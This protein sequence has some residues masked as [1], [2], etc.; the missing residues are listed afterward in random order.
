MSQTPG[1]Q[2][3]LASPIVTWAMNSGCAR[4]NAA[5]SCCSRSVGSQP[6]PTPTWSIRPSPTGSPR[7]G[8]MPLRSSIAGEPYAPAASTTCSAR[9]SPA[10]VARRRAV[11][12]EQHAVDE[13]VGEDRQVLAPA[14]RVE[15][16]EGR[17]PA[18]RA[19][20]VDRVQ[21]RVGAGRLGERARATA[22]APRGRPAHAQLRARRA[23]VG[24]DRRVAPAVAPLVVVRR[25]AREHHARVVRRAAADDA[26]AQLR[27][28]LAV[29]L[30]RVREGEPARVE[31][32]RRPAPAVVRAVVGPRLDQA[33]AP[34]ALASRAARTQPAE[35]PPTTSTSKLSPPAHGIDPIR[36]PPASA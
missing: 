21:D 27:A 9:S 16:G 7:S 18:H 34:P 35:P 6:K 29:G 19:D 13:R 22:T 1:A 17:V 20:G 32:V 10:D 2:A 31:H 23:E 24:L 12:V 3:L 4:S 36:R 14:R 5:V 26:R 25:R 8:P 15:V 33:D 28:V 11:A 30:P